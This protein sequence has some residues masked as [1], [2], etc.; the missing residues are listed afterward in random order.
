[1]NAINKTISV[2]EPV[3]E[4]IERTKTIL[5]RPFNLEK[6]FIIGFCAW[7]AGLL[8]GSGGGGGYG[9][10]HGHDGESQIPAQAIEFCR[11]HIVFIIFAVIA[12]VTIIAAVILVLLWLS[13]R[14]KFMF[15]DCLAKNKGH[16]IEP[17]KTFKKQ[18]NGLLGFRALLIAAAMICMIPLGILTVWFFALLKSGDTGVIIAAAMFFVVMLVIIIAVSFF[19]TVGALTFDFVVPIMYL[20]RTGIF[21]AWG[22]FLPMLWQNFWKIMLYLLFKVV[23][24]LCL[25]AITAAMVLIGCC[26]CCISAVLFIPYIGTVVL[27]P[28]SSFY[29]LYTLCYF[30]QF[31]SEYDVFA[32]AV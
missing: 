18:A 6:W 15:L 12:A 30:R 20:Q 29:R 13:S 14:G 32:A 22:K 28:L 11:I 8:E 10:G 24:L 7:L 26:F 1:M 19:G 17:W 31:G 21:T 25:G 2:I 23:I 5:F 16:I 3:N 4:A 9:G 27:L